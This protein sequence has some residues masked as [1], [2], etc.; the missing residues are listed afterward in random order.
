MK[1]WPLCTQRHNMTSYD[2]IDWKHLPYRVVL[3]LVFER[4]FLNHCLICV[5]ILVT[6]LSNLN[7]E[8]IYR[9]LYMFQLV[10]T[11]GVHRPVCSPEFKVEVRWV[12]IGVFDHL[13]ARIPVLWKIYFTFWVFV[14]IHVFPIAIVNLIRLEFQ[15]IS[16]NIS[17]NTFS[18]QI[19]TFGL[20]Y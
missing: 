13:I 16:A 7:T 20:F 3:L 9:L 19:V 18:P 14:L 8:V 5:V 6:S 2:S 15:S 17:T 12:I 1:K 10:L 11:Q 4:L